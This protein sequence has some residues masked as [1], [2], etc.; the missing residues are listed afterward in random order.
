MPITVP[1]GHRTV[2]RELAE[3]AH[4]DRQKLI[5]ALSASPA[6]I[7][8]KDF[9]SHVAKQADLT[10]E[11]ASP[12]I[13]MLI[14]M[15]RASKG[16][17]QP[18]AEEVVEAVKNLQEE[19][20]ASEKDWAGLGDDL[21]TILSLHDSLGLAAKITDVRTEYGSVYCSGRILTDIRPVFGA[22]PDSAPMAA[23]IVH[24]LRITYHAGES[25]KDFHVAL[26]ARDLR[27]LRDLV[28]RATKKERA[29]KQQ[30]KRTEMQYLEVEP[31]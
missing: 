15:Y 10:E 4:A 13:W 12:L 1:K 2:L 31:R 7:D 30:I 22:D 17:P 27:Q 16:E 9:I 23:A 14:S 20:D 29:L 25:H 28:E 26:D 8:P 21:A 11:Q 19:R 24:T 3:M 5:E 18:F 6:M